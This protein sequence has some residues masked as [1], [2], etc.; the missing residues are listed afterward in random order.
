MYWDRRPI[1]T[2]GGEGVC[3]YEPLPESDCYDIRAK[4]SDWFLTQFK[5]CKCMADCRITF[6]VMSLMQSGCVYSSNSLSLLHRQ[7][8][9]ARNAN[10]YN[11]NVSSLHL[12]ISGVPGVKVYCLFTSFVSLMYKL[13]SS[14]II[15][16]LFCVHYTILYQRHYGQKPI[17]HPYM[18]LA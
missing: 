16:L 12:C 5:C 3:S 18:R 6:T 15:C 11:W 10:D 7:L 13:S 14:D 4:C 17:A 1:R 2:W 8:Q 9:H